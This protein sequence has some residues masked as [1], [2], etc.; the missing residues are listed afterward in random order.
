MIL[1]HLLSQTK[2]MLLWPRILALLLVLPRSP[3]L[4][5]A[6]HDGKLKPR[7]QCNSTGNAVFY[8]H[9]YNGRPMLTAPLLLHAASSPRSQPLLLLLQ[10]APSSGVAFPAISA[11]HTT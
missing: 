8:H 2:S 3:R 5:L 1:L 11:I 7:H 6:R 4:R 10:P 9:I